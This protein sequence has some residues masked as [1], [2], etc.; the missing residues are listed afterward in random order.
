MPASKHPQQSQ[1]PVLPW[2]N[3]VVSEDMGVLAMIFLK[4]SED[5]VRE[6]TRLER[7]AAEGEV[8]GVAE[9]MAVVVFMVDDCDMCV[10]LRGNSVK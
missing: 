4:S 10:F 3:V 7:A 8:G 9:A 6:A 1:G 2:Q 5:N